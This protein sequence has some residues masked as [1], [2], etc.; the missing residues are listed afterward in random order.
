MR[1]F[2]KQDDAIQFCKEIG[3]DD[4]GVFVLH[5]CN[6]GMRFCVETYEKFTDMY[7]S[8]PI[9]LCHYY[10]VVRDGKPARLYFCIDIPD[11]DGVEVNGSSLVDILI[12]YVNH[13]LLVDYTKTIGF[14]QVLRLDA[15]TPTKFTQHLIYPE[16]VFESIQE[17]GNFVRRLTEAARAA[18]EGELTPN[19]LTQEF[20]IDELRLLFVQQP[21]VNGKTFIA[22][23]TVYSRNQHFRLFKSSSVGKTDH[24]EV[25][26][27]NCSPNFS[28]EQIFNDSLVI[29]SARSSSEL[30]LSCEPPTKK[31]CP[32][33][34]DCN[35]PCA[36]PPPPSPS[37]IPK[38]ERHHH[39]HLDNFVLSE[40]RKD[41]C[42]K[43]ALLADNITGKTGFCVAYTITGSRWCG[44]VQREHTT[45]RPYFVANM[46]YGKLYQMCNADGCRGWRSPKI[47]IPNDI[48]AKYFIGDEQTLLQL[49]LATDDIKNQIPGLI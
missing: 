8:Y 33:A 43:D 21:D 44:R 40:I 31:V 9:D 48:W 13:C 47:S 1:C 11:C 24:L 22:N 6:G 35:F 49:F 4:H 41:P 30:L 12:R 2:D 17:C 18:V 20:S 10:E 45:K 7:L 5:K 29:S 46:K 3:G 37:K 28:D 19:E 26:V 14:R 36:V 42:Y 32:K 15:T 38:F 25:A 16:V 34:V 39:I 27:E 23:S